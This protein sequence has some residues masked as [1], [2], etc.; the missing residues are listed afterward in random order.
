[1]LVYFFQPLQNEGISASS[2]GACSPPTRDGIPCPARVSFR[3]GEVRK[4]ILKKD[5]QTG[6]ISN[7]KS[8]K[9]ILGFGHLPICSH[10]SFAAPGFWILQKFHG[11][12]PYI[13]NWLST[14][15]R[16]GGFPLVDARVHRRNTNMVWYIVVMWVWDPGECAMVDVS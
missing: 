3:V 12:G 10:S 13:R 15:T 5:I 16:V 14:P 7:P 6:Q 11:F 9:W 4:S 8:K 1:M 2:A